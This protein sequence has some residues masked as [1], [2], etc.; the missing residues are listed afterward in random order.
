MSER[1]GC[2][3]S[4]AAKETLGLPLLSQTKYGK[5]ISLGQGFCTQTW[6]F[7]LS[8]LQSGLKRTRMAW[9]SSTF[10]LMLRCSRCRKS[11]VLQMRMVRSSAQ[12]ARYLPLL[13][14][15]MQDMFPLWL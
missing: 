4:A 9:S 7:S 8:H 1:S 14:K 12:V 15:S 3:L 11:L 5:A 13:L 10:A 6:G 2:S